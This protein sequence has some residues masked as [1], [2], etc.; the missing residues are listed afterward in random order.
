MRTKTIL[1]MLFVLSFGAAT[2]LIVRAMPHNVSANVE[3]VPQDE[4]L[5]ATT[6]L[7][8]GTL[9]R[10]EDVGWHPIVSAAEPGQI[11]RPSGV[12]LK[13]KPELDE[14][15]RA[16]VYGSVL[17]VDVAPGEPIL[18]S[19]IV[20]PGDREFLNVVLSPGARAISIPVVT[21]GAGTGI[22]HPGDR[23][24]VI[25]TQTFKTDQTP[26]PRRSVGETV[27][28]NLRVL[29]IDSPEAKQTNSGTGFGRTVTLEVMPEQAE[30]INVAI[31]LGKLSLVLRGTDPKGAEFANGV[32]VPGTTIGIRPTWAGDVSPALRAAV[33]PQAETPAIRQPMRVM[34]GN[35][36]EEWPPR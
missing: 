9:L 35:Q 32:P 14:E 12:A 34:R 1:L 29:A 27:V 13:L 6:R 31:E 5:V 4:I 7:G 3:P 23:V 24:D 21:G 10:A 16:A 26:L 22:L 18:R 2:L 33:A 19:E 20:M 17:R 28:L 15:A 30:K 25:L 8:V 36:T 11:A